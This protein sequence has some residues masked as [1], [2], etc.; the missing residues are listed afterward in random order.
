MKDGQCHYLPSGTDPR[1][2]RRHP[3]RRSANAQRHDV[4]RVRFQSRRRPHRQA[5]RPAR[6]AGD[7]MHRLRP[8]KTEP[9]PNKPAASIGQLPHDRHPA[10]KVSPYF[11]IEKV[12][13]QPRR[14][15]TDSV[16]QP[17]VWMMLAG[18]VELSTA[19]Q[20][21]STTVHPRRNRAAAGEDGKDDVM[22]TSAD[23]SLAGSDVSHGLK[24]FRPLPPT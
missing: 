16:R 24:R 9:P 17:V 6:R 12:A 8:G 1:A 20:N 19:A 15:R 3:R 4:P 11:T 18:R 7:G 14:R 22:K 13:L 5:A 23:S 2:G 21:Q 10:G